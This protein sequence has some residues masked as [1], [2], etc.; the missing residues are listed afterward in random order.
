MDD[1]ATKKE[2]DYGEMYKLQNEAILEHLR[3]GV[4]QPA[5]GSFSFKDLKLTWR[6]PHG[7]K[8]QVALIPW[9]KVED[10]IGGE[11]RVG[12]KAYKFVRIDPRTNANFKHPRANCHLECA[13][14]R[15]LI[16]STPF[17]LLSPFAMRLPSKSPHLPSTLH[18]ANMKVYWMHTHVQTPI[19]TC[20]VIL[21]PYQSLLK[22]QHWCMCGLGRSWPTHTWLLQCRHT[23]E[24][25]SPAQ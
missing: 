9:E 25:L 7:N 2:D 19:V 20:N 24:C 22:L 21:I 14:F 6:I 8:L 12:E 17:A 13:R 16:H 18:V 11:E 1:F 15:L 3:S 10:F 5:P 23:M 4:Q